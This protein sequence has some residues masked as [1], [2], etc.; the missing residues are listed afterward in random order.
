MLNAVCGDGA[1]RRVVWDRGANHSAGPDS[2]FLIEWV[3][4]WA[5]KYPMWS[6]AVFVRL[7]VAFRRKTCNV[8]DKAEDIIYDGH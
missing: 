4:R 5:L 2:P 6:C 8:N 1:V 3:R 7:L